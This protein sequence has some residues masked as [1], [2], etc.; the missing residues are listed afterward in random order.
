MGHR[1]AVERDVGGNSGV[2]D[3]AGPLHGRIRKVGTRLESWRVPRSRLSD[4][5]ADG[6]PWW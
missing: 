2:G 4:A 1:T 6:L 5:R 3:P